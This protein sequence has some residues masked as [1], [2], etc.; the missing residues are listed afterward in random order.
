MP[1]IKDH[2]GSIKG[3]LGGAGVDLPKSEEL[4]APKPKLDNIG[5]M[6]YGRMIFLE[7]NLQVLLQAL[8]RTKLPSTGYRF[9]IIFNLPYCLIWSPIYEYFW[10]PLKSRPSQGF[11]NTKERRH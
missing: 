5:V 8:Y 4:K 2:K 6:S 9:G 7:D 11:P 3:Y 10:G 1:T